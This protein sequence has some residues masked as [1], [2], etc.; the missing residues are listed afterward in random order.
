[1]QVGNEVG[2]LEHGEYLNRLMKLKRDLYRIKSLFD[3][4]P[5][6]YTFLLRKIRQEIERLKEPD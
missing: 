3:Q 6:E 2:F 5:M 4:V 1:M